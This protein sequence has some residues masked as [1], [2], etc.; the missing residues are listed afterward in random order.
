MKLSLGLSTLSPLLKMDPFTSAEYGIVWVSAASEAEATALAQAVVELQLAA[1]VSI[2][3]ITS[4]Y[5]WEGEVCREA[6]WQLM[7]K[8]KRS[9]FEALSEKIMALHSYEVPEVIATPVVAG[10][11]AYLSWIEANTH[12]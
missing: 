12:S 8:T 5:T 2:T 7:I 1:C 11:S 10:A 6:E 3:P 9:C 4:I